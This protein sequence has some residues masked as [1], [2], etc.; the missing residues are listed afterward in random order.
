[1]PWLWYTRVL[2]HMRVYGNAAS[3][4][5]QPMVHRWQ[6][7]IDQ[8]G[9]LLGDPRHGL[10]A[11]QCSPAID[12]NG[13]G[14]RRVQR[15]FLGHELTSC[16][17]SSTVSSQAGLHLHTILNAEN[18][19]TRASVPGTPSSRVPSMHS[20]GPLPTLTQQYEPRSS[21]A[22]DPATRNSVASD[23]RGSMEATSYLDSRRSSVDSRMNSGLTHLN[24]SPG[25]PY[26]SRN[27]SHASL[28]SNLNQQRGGSA[29]HRQSANAMSPLGPRAALS[30]TAARKVVNRV[31][32]PIHPNPRTLSGAPD[33]MADAPT[34]GFAWAFP[35]S[36]EPDQEGATPDGRPRTS[37][38]ASTLHSSIHE[39]ERPLPPGQRRLSEVEVP[40]YT[41]HHSL[42]HRSVTN[43]QSTDAA[44]VVGG[45][46]TGNY[47]RTPEL[48][49]SHKMAERKRRSEMKGLFDELNNILPNSPGSKSS[50]WEILTKCKPS[51]GDPDPNTQLMCHS[52]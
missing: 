37:S 41:H 30:P 4:R 26:E 29:E 52:H 39:S 48:R 28:N 35:A 50:K 45:T 40:P 51:L 27:Q 43:L 18:S 34:K 3:R 14:T 2:R 42:Q 20:Q 5:H 44:S 12:S 21:V 31:A 23:Q 17:D 47:S 10:V 22:S 32:P 9:E 38:V 6:H 46:S 1:M 13:R 8:T 15:F 25:S 16:T 24:L 49:V 11:S 36:A 19:P 33:P 7:G